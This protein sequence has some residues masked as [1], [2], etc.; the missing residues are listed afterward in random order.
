M[1]KYPQILLLIFAQIFA[2]Y[3]QSI[4]TAIFRSEKIYANICALFWEN[5][6]KIIHN[7][8]SNFFVWKF[9]SKIRNAKKTANT[10]QK[11]CKN[12]Q[13]YLR[14]KNFRNFFRQFLCKFFLKYLK[15]YMRCK[16]YR[17]ILR[18]YL[19]LEKNPENIS[20]F[21]AKIFALCKKTANF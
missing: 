16:K 1:Q 19:R 21:L 2:K 12:L 6:C 8:K 15:K 9:W 5:I 13:Q 10:V 11:Y 20:P 17:Q 18:Y 4:K 14:P 3:M 7:K